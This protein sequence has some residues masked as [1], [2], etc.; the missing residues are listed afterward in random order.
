MANS[1]KHRRGTRG[2][3]LSPEFSGGIAAGGGFDFQTRYATCHLPIWLQEEGF[4]QLLFEGTG[5][6]DIRFEDKRGSSRVHI[7]VKDHEVP[8]NEFKS[9][10]K[11]FFR[12]DSDLPGVYKRFVLACPSLSTRLRPFKKA[13][14]RY[15]GA[16]PFYDDVPDALAPT[17]GDLAEQFQRVGLG[18]YV[19]F[20]LLNVCVETGLSDL[21]HDNR[22]VE[23][24]VAR[25][26][27][28]PA[29]SEKPRAL[30]QPAFSEL[31]RALTARRGVVFKRADIEEV[32][33][34]AI[35][36][37]DD[38]TGAITI[39]IQNWT[40]ESFEPPAD[41]TLDWSQH[42]DRTSRRVPSADTWN[43]EL[44]PALQELRK[45]VTAERTERL[46]RFRGK[47]ALSTGVAIG[48]V[49]PVV[50]GWL[51]EIPQPPSTDD[52]RSNASPTDPYD[53]RVEILDGAPDGTDIVL[54]LNIKGDGRNDIIGWVRTGRLPR[55]FVFISPPSHGVQAIRGSED[56]CAFARAAREQ[57]GQLLKQYRLHHTR[58]FFYGPFALAVFLG[59]HLT[60][61]G[62]VQVYEYQD[63][64][65]LKSCVLQT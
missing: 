49:F 62:E 21:R 53:L 27:N 44:L 50:G 45:N 15:R 9:V 10:V 38:G 61:I 46:I 40:N 2:S 55:L 25:L 39:W 3:L 64:G 4:H 37:G 14:A 57:L 11:Q 1:R 28:L 30:V 33:E 19:E 58:L 18:D 31:M 56:A 7:Q 36:E 32:L 20:T 54:G 41:Y 29:Y 48:A 5:D 8:P 35:R 23:L 51:F 59:Q 47:C 13:L 34:T 22:A 43:K 17:E 26:Q 42:F 65:Y 24:F 52:W 63:P 16:K 12:L 60:S 6:I